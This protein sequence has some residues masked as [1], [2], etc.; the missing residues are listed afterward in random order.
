MYR[1]GKFATRKE[2]KAFCKTMGI[3][4]KRVTK[5]NKVFTI[6]TALSADGHNRFMVESGLEKYKVSHA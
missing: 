6:A 4:P 1:Y 3:D 5:M 2:A